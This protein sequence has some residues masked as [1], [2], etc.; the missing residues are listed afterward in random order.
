M[1]I[2]TYKKRNTHI[3]AITFE[4]GRDNAMEICKWVGAGSSYIAASNKDPREY[5]QIPTMWGPRDMKVGDTVGLIDDEGTFLV[6][7]PEAL[8]GE[9]L[10]VDHGV[11]KLVAHATRELS[12]FP[13]E[14]PE[15]VEHLVHTVQAFAE[16]KGHSGASHELA[17]MMVKDLL[18][19]NNLYGLTNDPEEWDF[20]PGA[21]YGIE[22]D[23]WQNIRNSKALSEDGGKT[24]WLVGE[25]P[26]EEERVWHT[27]IDKD[28]HPEIVIEEEEEDVTSTD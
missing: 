4:G 2:K 5:V 3:L 25:T 8:A 26:Q 19:M 16:Y 20:K 13:N 21:D 6:F 11:S 15:F 14:D 23:M 12:Y 10:E 24:Y 22:T 17:V 1:T 9:Y 18:S 27:A 28:T 7:K